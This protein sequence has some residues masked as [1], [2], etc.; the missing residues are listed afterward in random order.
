MT[1]QVQFIEF[2][3]ITRAL[4]AVAS[5]HP[6]DTHGRCPYGHVAQS[7]PLMLRT[8]G[9]PAAGRLDSPALARGRPVVLSRE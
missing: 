6:C 2:I 7:T 4:N 5:C 3:A 1:A 8:A 9:T